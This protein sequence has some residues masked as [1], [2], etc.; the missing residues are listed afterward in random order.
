MPGGVR[1]TSSTEASVLPVSCSTSA[2]IAAAAPSPR[3]TSKFRKF[4]STNCE[5]SIWSGSRQSPRKPTL[6]HAAMMFCGEHH[7]NHMPSNA[8]SRQPPKISQNSF[9]PMSTASW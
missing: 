1:T 2:R 9:K 4:R 3:S 7:V 5:R 6:R 8:R